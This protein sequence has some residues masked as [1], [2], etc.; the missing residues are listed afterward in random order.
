MICPKP[1]WRATNEWTVSG[2]QFQQKHQ[3]TR[4]AALADVCWDC[5]KLALPNANR[6]VSVID[7]PA[8]LPQGKQANEAFTSRAGGALHLRSW[9]TFVIFLFL[10]PGEWRATLSTDRLPGYSL[11]GLFHRC[12]DGNGTVSCATSR[13]LCG[14]TRSLLRSRQNVS[15]YV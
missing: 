8:R 3:S 13:G 2:S 14:R 10:Y 6:V 7:R 1:G 4:A 9:I 12:C 11:A 5:A 15:P